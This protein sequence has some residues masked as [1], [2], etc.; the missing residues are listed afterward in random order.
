MSHP[1]FPWA[2]DNTKGGEGGVGGWGGGMK[3]VI[4]P[5]WLSKVLQISLTA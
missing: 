3:I 2:Y 1:S 4:S 5:S